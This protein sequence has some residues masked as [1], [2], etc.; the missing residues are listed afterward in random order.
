[1]PD[2]F[3]SKGFSTVFALLDVDWKRRMLGWGAM[4]CAQRR[5]GAVLWRVRNG[6]A[7][8]SEVRDT[9]NLRVAAGRRERILGYGAYV[10]KNRADVGLIEEK[11]RNKV[12]RLGRGENLRPRPPIAYVIHRGHLTN[13]SGMSIKHR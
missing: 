5:H 12:A 13:I 7:A 10:C 2:D 8:D 1:M 4:R 3:V 9:R 11:S 6:E